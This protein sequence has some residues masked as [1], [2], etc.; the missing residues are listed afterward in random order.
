MSYATALRALGFRG[1]GVQNHYLITPPLHRT[2]SHTVTH[3]LGW[4]RKYR[5]NQPFRYFCEPMGVQLYRDRGL[6]YARVCWGEDGGLWLGGGPGGKGAK[7]PSTRLWGGSP[8]CSST[9][10]PPTILPPHYPTP[11]Y[12]TQSVCILSGKMPAPAMFGSLICGRFL[13]LEVVPSL[14]L[15]VILKR[16]LSWLS[17]TGL[18]G[19]SIW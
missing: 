14:C 3:L 10:L 2:C 4:D 6:W 13:V 18:Q 12:P 19:I 5:A 1:G 16:A 9:I 17:I 15:L 11:H 7:Q 8:G